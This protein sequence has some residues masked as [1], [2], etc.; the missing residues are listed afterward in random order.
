MR[1][2]KDDSDSGSRLLDYNS[3]E[4]RTAGFSRQSRVFQFSRTMIGSGGL[5]PWRT[6]A[7]NYSEE[8]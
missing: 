7:E 2:N 3:Q 5:K 8:T 6:L 4:P 1:T